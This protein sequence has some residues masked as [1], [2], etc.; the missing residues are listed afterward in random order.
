MIAL[1]LSPIGRAVLGLAGLAAFLAMFAYDQRNRGAEKLAANIERND[2]AAA[3]K[4]RSADSGSR[5]A[6]RVRGAIRDPNAA[7][8]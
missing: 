6:Q 4:I 7:S 5:D 3:T 2:N 1:L 8:E